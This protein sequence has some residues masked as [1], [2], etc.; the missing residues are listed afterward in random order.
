M[1]QVACPKRPYE[2]YQN[3]SFSDR[4][5]VFIIKNLAFYRLGPTVGKTTETRKIYILWIFMSYFL[6][7]KD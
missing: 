4:C 2:Y 6:I 1:A 7:F 5:L 3:V